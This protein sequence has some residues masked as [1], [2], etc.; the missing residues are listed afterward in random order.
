M[1]DRLADSPDGRASTGSA[2]SGRRAD[3]R[4]E[5]LF[6]ELTYRFKHAVTQEVAYDALETPANGAPPRDRRAARG[7]PRR[8]ARRARRGPRLTIS[9]EAGAWPKARAYLL[10]A[11]KKAANAFAIREALA[12]YDQA[13]AA[14]GRAGRRTWRPS[15]RFTGRSPTLYF[16]VSDFDRARAEAEQGVRWRASSAIASTRPRR[17]PGSPGPPSGNGTSKGRSR[18]RERQSTWRGRSATMRSWLARTSR[19]GTRGVGTG[20]LAEAREAIGQALTSGRSSGNPAYLS[21]SLSMAGQLQNWEGDYHAAS[22]LQ[23]EAL[24]LARQHNHLVPLLFGFFY[25]GLTLGGQGQYARAL[26]LFREGVTLAERIGDEMIHHSRLLNCLGWLHLELGDFDRAIELS[27]RSA[28]MVG[29]GTPRPDVPNAEIT[30]GNI[31]LAKGD[32][33][34]AGEFLDGAVRDS[35][36]SR[37]EPVDTMAILDAAI[38]Q[39]GQT[40]AGPRRPPHD[41]RIRRPVP[42]ARHEHELAEEP[43]Q[44]VAPSRRDRAGAPELR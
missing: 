30:L 23:A 9:P 15:S 21:L 27:G 34:Q 1:I 7:A 5:L 25:H 13:L 35:D 38:R 14:A 32:L 3:S 37:S 20:A 22:E 40:V 16:V 44:G 43:D 39:P 28:E 26:A 31:Y 10:K 29:A 17:C 11:A 6:P 8:P 24:E 36:P 12:L 42:R 33:V 18:T 41:R 2:S 4:E 19:S